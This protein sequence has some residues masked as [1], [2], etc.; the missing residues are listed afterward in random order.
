MNLGTINYIKA[1]FSFLNP[2]WT[3]KVSTYHQKLPLDDII[4]DLSTVYPGMEKSQ[5]FWGLIFYFY[6]NI[7]F[8]QYIRGYRVKIPVKKSFVDDLWPVE[9]YVPS[10]MKEFLIFNEKMY[11]FFLLSNCL[12][13]KQHKSLSDFGIFIGCR[14]KKH[15]L[16][17]F[18][19]HFDHKI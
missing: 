3:I 8:I 14:K 4:L 6:I 17:D 2:I 1:G 5:F 18:L 19:I 15:C 10:H 16:K 7:L 12:Y 9:V 13:I 11:F